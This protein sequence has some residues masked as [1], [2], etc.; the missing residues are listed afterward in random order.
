MSYEL[1]K[2]GSWSVILGKKYY[3]DFFKVK[4]N[5]LLK[6]TKILPK[7]NETEH[8]DLV[9]EIK[10]YNKFYTIP[11]N[12]IYILKKSDPFHFYIKRL[13]Q[14]EKLEIFDNDLHCLCIDYAGDNDLLDIIQEMKESKSNL[15]WKS[16]NDLLG[17]AKH[18][19]M[20][21]SFLHEKQLAHL[22]MKPENI[23]YNNKTKEF[24]II[25]FGF[26]HKYPFEEYIQS[27]RGTPGYFP[28][29]FDFEKPNKWLPKIETNDFAEEDGEIFMKREPSN[30]YKVD[31][32]CFGRVLYFLREVFEE[33]IQESCFSC[34]N[35]KSSKNNLDKI[36]I[37]LLD[38]NVRSRLTPKECLELL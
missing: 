38:N 31:S 27:P 9:R 21:L 1:L 36:I 7:H 29:Q 11:Y 18:I 23:M 5:V 22:D 32:F 12:E 14:Y 35:K 25:D 10:D 37:S 20:G 28:K 3:E 17:F 2:T 6:V 16:Y 8:L 24:R 30:V 13:V 33:N 26:T 19:L 34:F 4:K 15:F